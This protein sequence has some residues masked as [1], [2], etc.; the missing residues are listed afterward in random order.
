MSVWLS[1]RRKGAEALEGNLSALRMYYKM[2]VR[3]ITLTWN[4]ANELADGITESRGG[5]LT[6]FGG[7]AV[8]M[9]ES[10]GILI[11]VSHLSERVDWP[12]SL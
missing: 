5:G 7:E 1:T 8:S 11:D 12:S 10:M 4:Y 2:G 9:M 3:L 6:A